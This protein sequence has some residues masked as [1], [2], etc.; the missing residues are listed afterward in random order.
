[1]QNLSLICLLQVILCSSAYSQDN[2][3]P[4][5]YRTTCKVLATLVNENRN[6]L[7]QVVS[8]IS[9]YEIMNAKN[10][11]DFDE[12]TNAF[13]GLKSR[14]PQTQ[15]TQITYNDGTGPKHRTINLSYEE[16]IELSQLIN[17]GVSL[18]TIRLASRL[19]SAINSPSLEIQWEQDLEKIFSD[20]DLA[21]QLE[22]ESSIRKIILE[23]S[24]V[25]G[26][27]GGN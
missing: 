10:I 20:G 12:C 4:S 17:Q 27:S 19:E 6:D 25:A 26:S 8:I 24:S 14:M 15:P 22:L 5:E 13:E 9:V 1:M 23:T 21:Q 16:A 3:S 2:M 7:H 18:N 11:P